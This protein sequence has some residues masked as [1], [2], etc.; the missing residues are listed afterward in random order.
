MR[1]IYT[2]FVC[3]I[4]ACEAT[5]NRH[6]LKPGAKG[7]STRGEVV[8]LWQRCGQA[9]VRGDLFHALHLFYVEG[10]RRSP[11]AAVQAVAG[12]EVEAG[13]VFLGQLV[14]GAGGS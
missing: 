2:K 9:K 4:I 7:R 6:A 12:V 10:G 13:V 8:P 5:E 3:R 14:A 11:V 1:S